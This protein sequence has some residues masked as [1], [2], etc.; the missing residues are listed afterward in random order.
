[1][2]RNNSGADRAAVL[3]R[4]FYSLT[5]MIFMLG[6]TAP[7]LLFRGPLLSPRTPAP[8]YRL[9]AAITVVAIGVCDVLALIF[10]LRAL[11]GT[12]VRSGT[13]DGFRWGRR[14]VVVALL[15]TVVGLFFFG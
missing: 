5:V 15:T 4:L 3:R 2:G 14:L 9:G 12:S 1:M 7:Q 13:F 10:I 8:A 11:I 6:L